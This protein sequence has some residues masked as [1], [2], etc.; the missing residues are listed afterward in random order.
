MRKRRRSPA[1]VSS[2]SIVAEPF[3]RSVSPSRVVSPTPAAR[4]QS[5]PVVSNAGARPRA[6]KS[7][8]LVSMRAWSGPLRRPSLPQRLRRQLLPRGAGMGG[9]RLVA[10]GARVEPLHH[11]G[12]GVGALAFGH[13]CADAVA[14]HRSLHEQHVAGEASDAGAAV[15][16]RVDLELDLRAL[17]GAG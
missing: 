10:V 11:A 8:S 6:R 1:Q 14:V 4:V 3:S 17:L 5:T 2:S 7:P 16:A 15:G 13:A 12:L 9:A